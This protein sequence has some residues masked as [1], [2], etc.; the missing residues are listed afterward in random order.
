M[1]ADLEYPKLFQ[2]LP[3]NMLP[4]HQ[5]KPAKLNWTNQKPLEPSHDNMY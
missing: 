1:V 3:M 5:Y 4:A 2:D